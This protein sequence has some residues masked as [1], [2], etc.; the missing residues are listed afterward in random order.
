M[1]KDFAN[2]FYKGMH[3]E[4]VTCPLCDSNRLKK[5]Y[6]NDRYQMGVQTV[7]CKNC[8]LI[9]INPRPTE[10][11]MVGFYKN[12]YRNFYESIDVP[13]SHY[14]ANGPFIPRANFVYKV[15]ND[16]LNHANNILDVGCA[17]GTL[18]K[19]IEDSYPSIKTQGIEP[20]NG[21]GNYAKG[22]LRGEVFLGGYQEFVKQS[23][24][25][26]FDIITTT[27]VL[28]HILSPKEFVESLKSMMHESSVLYIEVPNIMSDNLKGL[29]AIH[30]G[31]VLSYDS[32]TLK[33]LLNL[34]GL[35]VIDFY[36][37]G[38]P[39]LT[40]AMGVI[41]KKAN[42]YN[43]VTYSTPS[44]VDQKAKLFI[45]RILPA[46]EEKRNSVKKKL[47]VLL[48]KLLG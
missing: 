39:A 47:K 3:K 45:E 43:K 9:H 6:D 7:I 26:K 48:N 12:H 1:V 37:E 29:G 40:P 14:I 21:F 34:C 13:T 5:L 30:L 33:L 27:H 2:T 17:E 41:C 10:Q 28:E 32:T 15:L 46:K 25:I 22:Q 42:K 38:L 11:E 24:N 36:T 18:L 4:K 8:S 35:E 23:P 16:Y 31:H 44:I 19:L 20:S